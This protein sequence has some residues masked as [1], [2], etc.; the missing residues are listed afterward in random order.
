LSPVGFLDDS[1]AK[2]RLTV[3]GLPI[4]G[5]VDELPSV[6]RERDVDEVLITMPSAAG[7]RTRAVVQLAHDAK[8][9]C[10]ILPGVTEILAG[11]VDLFRVRDVQVEDLLRREPIELDFS[12]TGD[13]IGGRVVLVS[14]AGGSIGSEIVRQVVRLQPARVLL[15]GQGENSLFELDQELRYE[16]PEVAHEVIVGSVRDRA[17]LEEVMLALRPD[18]VFHAAA[19]KHIPL[20]ERD[21]D[22]AILN[23]VGGTKNLVET[24]LDAHV[25]RFVNIST[26]KA[27]NPAS[28]VGAT[29][30]VAEKVVRALSKTADRDVSFVSVRF[31]NVLGSRGSV[32]PLFQ[33]QLRRGGPITVTHPDMTRYFMTIPEASRLVIQAGAL[34]RNDMVYLLD[35]G[36]PVRIGE[37]AD[38]MIRLSGTDP[39]DIEVI[40]AGLRPG[41]KLHEELLTEAE[42]TMPT[43]FDKILEASNEE[44]LDLDFLNRVDEL[45]SSAAERNWS[46]MSHVLN[47]LVPGFCLGDRGAVRRR[48]ES[49]QTL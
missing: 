28:M 23:N 1:R 38:D 25:E 46:K 27:V 32:I 4:L 16:L 33:E 26:D 10:R 29:K 37:L 45:L 11:E 34:G 40:Y 48:D 31:G 13:Y 8:V 49:T 41:E 39:D 18:V 15:F 19:H 43:R 42:H 22:E 24:A 35:M 47:E 12:E 21:P 3:A 7:A 44:P 2:R 36:T 6:A 9:S 17:K 5:T 14:G 20:M 30:Q